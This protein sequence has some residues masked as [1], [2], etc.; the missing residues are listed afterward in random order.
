ML[1]DEKAPTT[2]HGILIEALQKLQY[3]NAAWKP[4][5]ILCTD[6][7]IHIDSLQKAFPGEAL[8]GANMSLPCAHISINFDKK[9]EN[10]LVAHPGILFQGVVMSLALLLL[11]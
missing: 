11:V 4:N 10:I 8:L 9:K 7:Q 5:S 2:K 6:T 1:E 3:W